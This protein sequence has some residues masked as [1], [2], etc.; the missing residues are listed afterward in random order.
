MSSHLIQN[1]IANKLAKALSVASCSLIATLSMTASAAQPDFSRAQK[2]LKIMSTIFETS[3][4]TQANQQKFFPSK[5]TSAT[6]LAK[7]GMVFS[8]NFSH[9]AF[10]ATDGW[11][12][13]GEDI[14][15]FVGTFAN[16]IAGEVSAAISDEFAM[17]RPPEAP[18][19]SQ[20]FEERLRHYEEK[21]ELLAE[22]REK[23]EHQRDEVRELQRQIR[24]IERDLDGPEKNTEERK[25]VEKLKTELDAKVAALKQKMDQYKQSMSEYRAQREK[26]Y[27]E[28]AEN[29]SDIIISTLCDYGATL[30]SLAN[31]EHVTLIFKNYKSDYDQI[32]VF[33]H[34]DV[35][36]CSSKDKLK[37]AAIS[38]QL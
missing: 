18:E 14:G 12:A 38:Y 6:Y 28:S 4:K 30:R 1:F 11:A 22:M 5:K 27:T 34:K 3:L 8:F 33:S 16:E 26:K 36:D 9:S 17:P 7:Q 10:A 37:R 2:E 20:H 29:K 23:Q 19:A 35:A 32:Y 31:D 21:M 13:F 24:R 25:Q 15:Q